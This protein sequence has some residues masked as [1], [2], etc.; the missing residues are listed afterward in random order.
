[1]TVETNHKEIAMN[2]M[3]S[4]RPPRIALA[5]LAATAGLHYLSPAGTVLHFPYRLL[6]TVFGLAGFGIMMWAWMIFKRKK[7]VVCPTGKATTLIQSGPYQLTRNPMYLGML[8]MLCGAGF[9]LGSMMA[10]LA[11]IAFYITMNE[12]FIPFEEQNM[13][14][15]FGEE[16]CRYRGH[17]RRWI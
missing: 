6:G 13:E 14:Q 10:F 9:V 3:L 17:V 2:R 12:V 8:L 1:M 15:T 7:T 5:Y 16:Y 4:Y 11:P